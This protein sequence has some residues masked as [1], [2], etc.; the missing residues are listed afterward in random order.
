V[1]AGSYPLIQVDIDFI[2]GS[3]QTKA[4][5][6]NE[7][8]FFFTSKKMLPDEDSYEYIVANQYQLHLFIRKSDAP[9]IDMD[10]WSTVQRFPFVS[11]PQSDVTLTDQIATICRNRH[12][13][14]R[15][16]N[17]YNRV[18]AI[19]VSVNAG[20]GVAILPPSL[21]TYYPWPDVATLPIPGE[22]AAG[23]SVI[24]WN[25]T[26]DSSAAQAFKETVQHLFPGRVSNPP[27]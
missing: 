27:G 17:R 14:P 22:D 11:M 18:E 24:A 13:V 25:K 20:V 2:L 10:D 7:Y 19:I 6:R 5:I 26:F 21:N 23:V 16:I 15:I 4:F 8:D 9:N 3:S 1:F 12:C